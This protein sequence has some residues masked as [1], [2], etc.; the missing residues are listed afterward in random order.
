M[1]P[2]SCIAVHA[3]RKLRRSRQALPVA[4]PPLHL[5]QLGAY[6][7]ALP[8]QCVQLIHRVLLLRLALLLRL[9]GGTLFLTACGPLLGCFLVACHAVNEVLVDLWRRRRLTACLREATAN[10]SNARFR[11]K[12]ALRELRR[13]AECFEHSFWARGAWRRGS[14]WC[15]AP[16]VCAASTGHFLSHSKCLRRASRGAHAV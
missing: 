7:L 13:P 5:V 6:V 10:W 2:A 3:G 14:G 15:P 16:Q 11:W 8:F 1:W 9:C 4:H 12:T